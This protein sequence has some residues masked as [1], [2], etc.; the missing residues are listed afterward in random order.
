MCLEFPQLS[1]LDT[2]LSAPGQLNI[3]SPECPSGNEATQAMLITSDNRFSQLKTCLAT[4]HHFLLSR[5]AAV[6]VD[7]AGQD[8]HS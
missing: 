3:L 5:Q 2:I 6:E 7:R 1:W 4:A 8:G